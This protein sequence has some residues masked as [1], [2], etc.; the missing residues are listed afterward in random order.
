[1]PNWFDS[2]KAGLFRLAAK[3]MGYR[4]T[5][6]PSLEGLDPITARVTFT[7]PSSKNSDS[8]EWD[9]ISFENPNRIV[10]YMDQD[11]PGLFDAVE[12]RNGLDIQVLQIFENDEIEGDLYQVGK[13]KKV[14]DGSVI[15][16]E[17]FPYVEG[18][19]D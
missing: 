2:R 15:Y 11:F 10:S 12:N 17:V 14:F 16:A 3:A 7:Y 18:E 13:A 6:L 5:W 19:T 8:L 9:G 4:A 1:M